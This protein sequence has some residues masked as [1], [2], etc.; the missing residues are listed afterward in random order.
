PPRWNLVVSAGHARRSPIAAPT[1]PAPLA[2]PSTTNA[3]GSIPSRG[4]ATTDAD[5]SSSPSPAASPLAP[6]RAGSAGETGSA[7][8][9]FSAPGLGS[10]VSAQFAGSGSPPGMRVPIVPPAAGAVGAGSKT[11]VSAPK[12][13]ASTSS[14]SGASNWIASPSLFRPL[15]IAPSPTRTTPTPSGIAADAP[16]TTT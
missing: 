14:P 13:I 2:P 6:P 1:A 11:D 12:D 9:S 5:A 10:S 4:G 8:N 16:A 15:P 7:G 3:T